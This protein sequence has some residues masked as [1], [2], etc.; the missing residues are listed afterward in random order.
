VSLSVQVRNDDGAVIVALA[1]AASMS[2]LEQVL[3]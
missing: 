3:S 2:M 1:G